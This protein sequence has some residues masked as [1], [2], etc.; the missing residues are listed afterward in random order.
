MNPRITFAKHVFCFYVVAACLTMA[1]LCAFGADETPPC[2]EPTFA[3]VAYGPF[4][5][6]VLD[7]WQAPSGDAAP[8]VVC[9]HGGGFCA[10]DKR[11]VRRRHG[12]W[13]RR[14]QEANVALAS[15][16]YRFINTT[17]LPDILRDTSRAIQFLR[18]KAAEWHIDKDRVASFGESAGAGSSLWIAFRPDMA[19]PGSGDP[20]LR[21]STRLRAVGALDPQATYDFPAWPKLLDVPEAIWTASSLVIAPSYYRMSPFDLSS[22][23]A[24]AL[25]GDVDMLAMLTADAPPVYLKCVRSKEPPKTWDDLLHH[26]RHALLVKEKCDALGVPSVLV[27]RDTPEEARVDV[28][29]FLLDKL[30]VPQA[31]G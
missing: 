18:S 31:A 14:C 30:G 24:R 6:N 8:L 3:D 23:K 12:E 20:I 9:I 17:G 1:C 19:D 15:I 10:G 26:P 5:R 25:R 11:W 29:A 7:F 28:L 16:N 2:P 13:V 4:N 22:D 27:D 21:E